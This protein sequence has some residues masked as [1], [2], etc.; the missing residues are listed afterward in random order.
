MP[1]TWKYG[2]DTAA[3]GSFSGSPSPVRSAVTSVEAAI[4]LNDVA[5]R[6]QSR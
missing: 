1:K 2:D 5:C 3:I 4:A 6:A